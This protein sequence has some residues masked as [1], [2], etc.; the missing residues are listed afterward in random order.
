MTRVVVEVGQSAWVQEVADDARISIGRA[1]TNTIIIEDTS[2]SREHCAIERDDERRY[3]LLDLGSRNGTRLNGRFVSRALINPG[4]RI[5]IG[6]TTITF[7]GAGEEGAKAAE[8]LEKEARARA[9]QLRS[10]EALDALAKDPLTGLASFPAVILE[11]RRLLAA[12]SDAAAT[13]AHDIEAT[14]LVGLIKLDIDYLGLLNDMFGLRAGDDVIAQ[15]ARAL[16]SALA[17]R[18]EQR[19]FAGREAGGKFVVVLPGAEAPVA[20]GVAERVR[21]RVAAQVL[22]GS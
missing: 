4:D 12:S 14:P 1:L 22:E 2:A 13:T 15:V 9:D 20:E 16:V 17:E 10:A 21:Q 5:E 11:L 19:A 7:T 3:W 18:P 6:A 8:A